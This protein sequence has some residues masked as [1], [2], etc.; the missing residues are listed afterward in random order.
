MRILKFKHIGP[1]AGCPWRWEYIA[2]DSSIDHGETYPIVF[3]PGH[4]TLDEVVIAALSTTAFLRTEYRYRADLF[5]EFKWYDWGSKIFQEIPHGYAPLFWEFAQR[6]SLEFTWE[7][8]ECGD[9]QTDEPAYISGYHRAGGNSIE[10]E[11]W[12]CEECMW[13]E[14]MR[15]W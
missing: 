2:T 12:L 5:K 13:R 11:G 4:M 7:C 8:N 3:T 10:I 14:R 15:E 6:H 9:P 1:F